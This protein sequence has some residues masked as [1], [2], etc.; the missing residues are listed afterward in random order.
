MT[1]IGLYL[2]RKMTTS[3]AR[4]L[5][6]DLRESDFNVEYSIEAEVFD[7]TPGDRHVTAG[8]LAH[9]YPL[10]SRPRILTDTPLL[11]AADSETI[12]W[13]TP[14]KRIVTLHNNQ[15]H[16]TR[17]NDAVR[18]LSRH[19]CDRLIFRLKGNHGALLRSFAYEIQELRR[20]STNA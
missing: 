15:Y 7:S 9:L 10:V 20:A 3:F 4:M 18:T 11:F 6:I 8:H 2:L 1:A 19:E 13:L 5:I 17:L 16:Y 12:V 14:E